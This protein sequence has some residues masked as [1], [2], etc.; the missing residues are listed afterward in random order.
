[1]DI[2]SMN[3]IYKYKYEIIMLKLIYISEIS[4]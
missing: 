1:M 2:K 3:N 4:I